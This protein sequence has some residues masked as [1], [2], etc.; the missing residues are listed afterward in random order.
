MSRDAVSLC[1]QLLS[2]SAIVGPLSSGLSFLPELPD[3]H[4][5]GTMVQQNAGSA[6]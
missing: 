3:T 4:N 1:V 2:S 6:Y 5:E